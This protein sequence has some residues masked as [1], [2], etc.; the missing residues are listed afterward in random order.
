ML[1]FTGIMV[2]VRG[3]GVVG[4]FELTKYSPVLP[5]LLER[6]PEKN[7]IICEKI[8]GKKNPYKFTNPKL[9]SSL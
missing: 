7:R 8:V 5:V 6:V 1:Q 2:L 9:N 3:G 4:A